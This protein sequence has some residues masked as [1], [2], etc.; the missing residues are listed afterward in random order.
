[1]Y[2]CLNPDCRKSFVEQTG[3]IL[4]NT[5][6]DIDVWEKYI[7]CMVEKYPLFLYKQLFIGG[8]KFSTPY[9]G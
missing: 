8:M 2:L 5:H 1:M 9:K 6:K 4:Y 7:H 3:T